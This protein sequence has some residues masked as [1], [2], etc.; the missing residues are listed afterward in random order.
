MKKLVSVLLVLV[1]AMA[2]ACSAVA[3]EMLSTA[4]FTIEVFSITELRLR[5]TEPAY[6]TPFSMALITF[7]ISVVESF[8][9]SALLFARFLTSSATTAK[10]LP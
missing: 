10:P 9:A 1:M 5:S 7:P 8:A 2:V 4:S 3:E 6:P